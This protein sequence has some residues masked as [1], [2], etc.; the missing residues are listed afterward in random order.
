[1]LGLQHHSQNF[2]LATFDYKSLHI[3]QEG[4]AL[5][6]CLKSTKLWTMMQM[7]LCIL[8]LNN[9]YFSNGIFNVIYEQMQDSTK[10]DT[11]SSFESKDI[12]LLHRDQGDLYSIVNQSNYM[13]YTII[14][15]ANPFMIQL[16]NFCLLFLFYF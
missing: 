14:T 10:N 15:V 4:A 9:M 7:L 11:V 16:P 1:M 8:S 6:S 12:N 3:L 13:R 5:C 2:L